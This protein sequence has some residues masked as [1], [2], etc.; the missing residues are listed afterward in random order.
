MNIVVPMTEHLNAHRPFDFIVLHC[1]HALLRSVYHLIFPILF[2]K[3]I[4]CEGFD[5]VDVVFH[6]QEHTIIASL[7]QVLQQCQRLV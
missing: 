6:F 4:L 2:H 5:N 7:Q 3:T 1:L